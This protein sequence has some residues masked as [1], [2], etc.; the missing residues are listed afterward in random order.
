MARGTWVGA[1]AA[2]MMSGRRDTVGGPGIECLTHGDCAK[3][4]RCFAVPRD[5]PFV[6]A[7]KCREPCVDDLQCER[8]VRCVAARERSGQLVPALD[9][10]LGACAGR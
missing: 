10:G 7:G 1:I 4:L 9:G 8:G 2:F 6:T 3:S 5:A